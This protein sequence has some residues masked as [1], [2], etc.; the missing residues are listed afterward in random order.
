MSSASPFIPK[1]SFTIGA[2][3]KST[4]ATLT[5]KRRHDDEETMP[6][7]IQQRCF[8]RAEKGLVA[9]TAREAGHIYVKRQRS[10]STRASSGTIYKALEEDEQFY[11]EA[12][13]RP[14]HELVS[15]RLSNLG[16]EVAGSKRLRTLLAKRSKAR[17]RKQHGTW[18]LRASVG[19][20]TLLETISTSGQILLDYR[21]RLNLFWDFADRN[22]LKLAGDRSFDN[23]AADW[24]D[25]EFLSGE[26]FH[27]GE[28]LL[29]A[30]KKWALVHRDTGCLQLP[31]FEK[32]LRSWRKNSP[33]AARLPMP[34]EF[35]W[36]IVGI[37]GWAGHAEEVLYHATLF[38]CYPR[39]T[40]LLHL[41]IDDVIPAAAN[42]R[43]QFV[44]LVFAPAVREK[45]TKTG[46][47][48]ECILIDDK[49]HRDIGPLLTEQ[50]ERRR[51]DTGVSPDDLPVPLWSFDSRNLFL[52][53]KGAVRVA[54][55]PEMHSVYQSRHGGA[56]RDQLRKLR[57]AVEIQQRLRHATMNS[58]RIY[59]KPGRILE[60][61]HALSAEDFSFAGR[62]RDGFGSFIR[63]GGWPQPP[64]VPTNLALF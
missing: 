63:S 44:T 62:V 3:A 25:L 35:M 5:G 46:F 10:M 29:A 2:A 6:L 48:D 57:S 30:L 21:R 54:R 34:E 14:G 60:L 36:I 50:V 61:V 22:G 11:K 37:L 38:E 49:V 16:R 56:S 47:F 27:V 1:D 17:R 28:K 39:P 32:V 59:N 53:W 42:S 8:P 9:A 58:T 64:R 19:D 45:A 13:P 24:S 15:V 4:A 51:R 12:L 7:P 31:R 43:D 20:E 23:A 26:G 41:Y 18:K 52:R 33:A 55:L 40:E